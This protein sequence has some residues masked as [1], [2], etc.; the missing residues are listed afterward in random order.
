MFDIPGEVLYLFVYVFSNC[1]C[2]FIMRYYLE[3]W[4][5]AVI[6]GIS[7]QLENCPSLFCKINK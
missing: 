4:S 2:L 5:T 1:G 3:V 7:L 6:F